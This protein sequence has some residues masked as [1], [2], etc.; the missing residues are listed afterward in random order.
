MTQSS[1]WVKI[2]I[3]SQK[4]VKLLTLLKIKNIKKLVVN[5]TKINK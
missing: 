4:N 2:Y 3:T 1:H 5:L